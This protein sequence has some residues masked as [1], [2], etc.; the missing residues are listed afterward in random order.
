MRKYLIIVIAFIIYLEGSIIFKAKVL[1]VMLIQVLL[2]RVTVSIVSL[3]IPLLIFFFG[4][5]AHVLTVTIQVDVLKI[6]LQLLSTLGRIFEALLAELLN[7]SS[8][9]AA[10]ILILNER[11]CTVAKNGVVFYFPNVFQHYFLDLLLIHFQRLHVL[12]HTSWS[13]S[14]AV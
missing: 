9:N 14:L 11:T 8:F 7:H 10:L 6:N 1:L 12:D 13:R 3:Q 5:L 4:N 2:I